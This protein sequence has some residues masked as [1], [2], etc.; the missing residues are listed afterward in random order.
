VVAVV[1]EKVDHVK[2]V[3]QVVLVV[4]QELI[5]LQDLEK[6]VVQEIHLP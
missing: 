2:Q 1:V 4:E 6:L 3:Y 5:V